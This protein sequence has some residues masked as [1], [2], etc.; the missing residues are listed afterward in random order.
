MAPGHDLYSS[1]LTF[2]FYIHQT[3]RLRIF[4]AYLVPACPGY[5]EWVNEWDQMR[6]FSTDLRKAFTTSGSN[7]V[8]EQRLISATASALS[9]RSR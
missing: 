8:P 9:R 3:S 5:D 6:C 1:I 2:A 4:V 7:W